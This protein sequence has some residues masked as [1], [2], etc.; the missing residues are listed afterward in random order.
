MNTVIDHD[1]DL[2]LYDYWRSSA[3]YRVRICLHIKGLNFRQRAVNL[4]NGEQ[5]EDEYR[6]VNPQ[7]LVPALVHGGRV[8]TQSLAICEYLDD[9]FPQTPLLPAEPHLRAKARAMALSITS[10]I[11]PLN[12]LRVQNY[13]KEQLGVSGD[14]AVD[15]MNH[16]VSL[17]FQALE[18]NL[19]GSAE[20]GL[21]C[22]G[23]EPGLID[24]C[25]VPQIYNA[26]RF[27]C[28][29]SGFP[30][31]RRISDHCRALAPFQAA[32]PENQ[33]GAVKN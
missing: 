31:I 33:P 25:L 21:C 30:V 20:T 6:R 23:D 17:G 32:A 13:L 4:V 15:W 28:D 9:M 1:A 24:S 8:V 3:S 5:H 27:G 19:A 22:M 11:H 26:E 14:Q 10:D 18:I 29:L 2:T 7:G 12:N 16:W